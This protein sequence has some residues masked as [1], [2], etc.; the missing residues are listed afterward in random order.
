MHL[1][2]LKIRLFSTAGINRKLANASI[3]EYFLLLNQAMK[4]P[5]IKDKVSYFLH[6]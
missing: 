3:A 5:K 6:P 1:T 2:A 4:L